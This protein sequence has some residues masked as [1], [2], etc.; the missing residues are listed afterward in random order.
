MERGSDLTGED[1]I[2]RGFN[3]ATSRRTWR[4]EWILCNECGNLGFNGATSRRTWRDDIDDFIN[5]NKDLL[6][7]GHVQKDMERIPTG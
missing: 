3:G 1:D 5:D 7:W 2:L 4:D 6:Q